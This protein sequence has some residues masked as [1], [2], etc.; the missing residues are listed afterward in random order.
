M[1]DT[2]LG[3]GRVGG[4]V[5]VRVS[6]M[7]GNMLRV[8]LPLFLSYGQSFFARHAKEL[9]GACEPLHLRGVRGWW[10]WGVGVGG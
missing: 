2:K 5:R 9:H 1:R 10:V 8:G 6:T 7:G 3:R 4:V